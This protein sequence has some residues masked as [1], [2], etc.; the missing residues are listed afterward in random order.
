MFHI[1]WV[2]L[3]T[4]YLYS[5]RKAHFKI[6]HHQSYSCRYLDVF[7]INVFLPRNNWFRLFR[8]PI[9]C[10]DGTEQMIWKRN[11]VYLYYRCH[12]IK[13]F[14]P[15]QTNKPCGFFSHFQLVDISVEKQNLVLE[16]QEK[17]TK[18][19]MHG[20]NFFGSFLQHQVSIRKHMVDQQILSVNDVRI[21]LHM[22]IIC[23]SSSQDIFSRLQ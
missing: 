7:E 21:S 1:Q 9:H 5:T 4:F 12:M 18:A 23:L 3:I 20:H 2:S 11:S 19:F 6:S 14:P 22:A 15:K 10:W 13:Y 16:I 17:I 8:I